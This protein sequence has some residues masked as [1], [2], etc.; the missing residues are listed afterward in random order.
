MIKKLF[1][2]ILSPFSVRIVFKKISFPTDT[3]KRIDYKFIIY[4]TN[5]F[6]KI[7]N[8]KSQ[9]DLDYIEF[10][11]I[12]TMNHCSTTKVHFESLP[13]FS[14]SLSLSS[15][16]VRNRINIKKISSSC[17]FPFVPPVCIIWN[18]CRF[19]V[20]F[21]FQNN[22]LI[23]MQNGRQIVLNVIHPFLFSWVG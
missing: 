1:R 16:Y 14:I 20:P 9:N 23:R 3:S 13:S 5:C 17:C 6:V 11:L 7:N 4:K 10:F 15:E 2:P 8:F 19:L 12:I 21:S 22:L 18:C